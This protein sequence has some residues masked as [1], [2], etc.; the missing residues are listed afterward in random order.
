MAKYESI[1]ASMSKPCGPRGMNEQNTSM[2]ELRKM[3]MEPKLV[4]GGKK[5]PA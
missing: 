3:G 1:G 2:R 5:T 4:L